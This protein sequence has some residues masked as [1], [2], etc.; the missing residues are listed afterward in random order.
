[1]NDR[2]RFLI[3]RKWKMLKIEF[4]YHKMILTNPNIMKKIKREHLFC[5]ILRR[6]PHKNR[7]CLGGRAY[8]AHSNCAYVDELSNYNFC[9]EDCHDRIDAMYQDMWDEYNSGRY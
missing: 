8:L 1:M 9:C 6:C 4:S 2:T 5:A 3:K 7:E